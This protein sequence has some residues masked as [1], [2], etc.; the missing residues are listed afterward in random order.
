MA[1]S[2]TGDKKILFWRPHGPSA[3]QEGESK[4]TKQGWKAGCT[5]AHHRKQRVASCV[6]PAKRILIKELLP[7]NTKVAA[8]NILKLLHIYYVQAR[9]RNIKKD[10]LPCNTKVAN[11][12]YNSCM[13]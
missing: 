1:V 2:G 4:K 3:L 8:Q 5:I 11:V 7:Y 13:I 6:I 9:G 12:Y 10:L